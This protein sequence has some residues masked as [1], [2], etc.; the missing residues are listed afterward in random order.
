MDE[1]DI[2]PYA[3]A[4]TAGLSESHLGMLR[5]GEISKPR[6]QTVRRLAEAL[7][8]PVEELL[9]DHPGFTHLTIS[10]PEELIDTLHAVAAVQ[11]T[12]TE[13]VIEREIRDLL[14]ARRSEPAIGQ[15]IKAMEAARQP[16][17]GQQGPIAR[18]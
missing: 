2:T 3:L 15:V 1:L 6:G 5:R 14:V 11:R 17:V 8:V 7:N 4:Q 12:S 13:A 9:S 16:D 10:I 18:S